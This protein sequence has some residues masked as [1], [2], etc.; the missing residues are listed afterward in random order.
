MPPRRCV[1]QYCSRVS[2]KE[3]GI[4]VH[5]SPS[6]GNNRTKWRRFVSQHRKN[7][8][9]TGTFG[10]CSLHFKTDC[11]TRA[12][13][14]KGTE[15]RLK[16]GSLPTIWKETPGSISERSR[17]RVSK[18][19]VRW[20][21][22]SDTHSYFQVFVTVNLSIFLLVTVGF[23][24]HLNFRSSLFNRLEILCIIVRLMNLCESSRLSRYYCGLTTANST[25]FLLTLTCLSSYEQ[26]KRF[27]SIKTTGARICGE[28]SV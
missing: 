21:L 18:F 12:V 7:F 8:N 28:N 16:P 9:P 17:R 3:L 26:K 15:R 19:S 4:S 1:V 25:L 10:I 11:F 6:S 23:T 14:V 27:V 20:C 2:D 5:T 24:I 22:F 13:H